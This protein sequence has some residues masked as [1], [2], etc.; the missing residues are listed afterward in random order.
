MVWGTVYNYLI[1][2]FK[3]IRYLDEEGGGA[4][5]C[6]LSFVLNGHL[7]QENSSGGGSMSSAWGHPF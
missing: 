4:G 7:D 5:F 2:V 1:L 6:G 3:G